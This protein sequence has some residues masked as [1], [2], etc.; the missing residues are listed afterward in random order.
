L[1]ATRQT[2]GSPEE[3]PPSMPPIRYFSLPKTPDLGTMES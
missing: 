1:T 2:I 3:M